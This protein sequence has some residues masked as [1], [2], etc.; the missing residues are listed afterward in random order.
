MLSILKEPRG[1][2]FHNGQLAISSE[3]KAYVL[4]DTIHII[5]NDWFFLYTYCKFSPFKDENLLISSSGYD[6]VF[7]YNWKQ[8]TCEWEWFAWENG[9]F[10]GKDPQT[11]PLCFN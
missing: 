6:C 2:D 11:I 3:N 1:I 5:Q 7:E 10:Q 9:M 8:N 4:T